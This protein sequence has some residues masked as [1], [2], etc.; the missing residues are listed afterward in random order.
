MSIATC[1]LASTTCQI[2]DVSR[3][4]SPMLSTTAARSRN[5]HIYF[6][7]TVARSA[8]KQ[9]ILDLSRNFSSSFTAFC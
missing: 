2:V 6:S 7:V 8:G 5:A 4:H 1:E 9:R 3:P